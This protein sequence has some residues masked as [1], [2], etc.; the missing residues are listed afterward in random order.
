MGHPAPQLRP[1]ARGALGVLTRIV[2]D[3]REA[4][5]VELELSSSSARTLG[6]LS[7]PTLMPG[8]LRPVG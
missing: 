6:G 3:I 5:A 4:S 1:L 8:W 2:V 7:C